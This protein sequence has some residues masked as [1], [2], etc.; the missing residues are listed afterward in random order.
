MKKIS[1]FIIAIFLILGILS[2]KNTIMKLTLEKAVRAISGLRL[3][4]T[5]VDIG[6]IRPLIKV[7]GLT[8]LNPDKFPDRTMFEIPLIYIEYD[9]ASLFGKQVHLKEMALEL[10]ELSVIRNADGELNLNSLN[11]VKKPARPQAKRADSKKAA[12]SVRIDRLHLKAG[13]VIYKDYT[14]APYPKVLEF[15]I[16]LDERYENIKDPYALGKLIVTRSLYKT[17]IS[18]LTG[19]D[20]STLEGTLEGIVSKGAGA[21]EAASKEVA[22]ISK[23]L[24]RGVGETLGGTTKGALKDIIKLPFGKDRNDE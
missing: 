11:L 1:V 23:E 15:S 13:K 14:Q 7:R 21:L 18:Q 20:L 5:A 22:G 12:P 24:T 10:K 19:F 16:N 6:F 4:V 9:V 2:A 3:S 8:L 17:S